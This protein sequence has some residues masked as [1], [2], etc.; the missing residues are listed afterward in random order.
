MNLSPLLARGLAAGLALALFLGSLR[1]LAAAPP[2]ASASAPI[3]RRSPPFLA[4]LSSGAAPLPPPLSSPPPP[5]HRTRLVVR[6]DPVAHTL[7]AQGQVTW[8]N[9][10]Q[11]PVHDTFW[12]L[13][14]NAFQHPRTAFLRSRLGEGR[15]DQ[16]PSTWGRIKLTRL[17]V[18]SPDEAP[19]R[20]VDLLPSLAPHSPDDPDDQ[21]D[22]RAPLPAPCQPQQSLVFDLAFEA[23]LPSLVERTG[24]LENFHMVGQW[25]PKLARLRDDG[26]WSH[27][28]FLRLSEFDADFGDYDITIEAPPT[29]VVGATGVRAEERTENGVRATRFLQEG[30]HDFAWTAWDQFL[31]RTET[32]DGVPVRALYPRGHEPAVR[33]Q[34]EG[35]RVAIPCMRRRLGPYP[36]ASLTLVQPPAGAGEAGGMEYPTLITTGGPWYGPPWLRTAEAVA[37]HE[38]GHQYFYGLLASDE[39]RHPFLDEGLNTLVEGLCLREG[40]GDG[41]LL[42][43]PGLSLDF[44]EASR[45]MGLGA[46]HDHAIA[47]GAASFP[48]AGHY[49]RLAYFRAA[50]LLATLRGAFGEAPFDEALQRYAQAFRFRHP[51]PADLVT[52]LGQ[53]DPALAVALDDGLSRRGWIDFAVTAFQPGWTVIA[54]RGSLQLPVTVRLRF[55][56]GTTRDERWDGTSEWV[57]FD[58]NE[59]AEL[60][61]VEV[62]PEHRIL[63]D[64][65]RS[66]N[67]RS[68]ERTRV[69]RATLERGLFWG[70]LL[71]RL[72]AP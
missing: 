25:F 63:L 58:I 55:V 3:Q 16:L 70:G 26:T 36:Y 24:F 50:I 23:S 27:F 33:R 44:L 47:H 40:H 5:V 68:R 13:Y 8:T 45:W 28:P 29:Y 64:E 52:A 39:H 4:P 46:G 62:D 7:Q 71:G 32:L 61:A 21:T 42:A 38:Y 18:R 51:E 19:S 37:V 59:P 17:A 11:R 9:R 15:G 49:G 34:L 48:T 30:V 1:A 60:Q 43:A 65:D 72:L 2:A 20:A 6:L 35:L 56:D 41:S 69:G 57:R 54:R 53:V 22:L 31:E 10:S 12:H 67:A 66:N 14:L